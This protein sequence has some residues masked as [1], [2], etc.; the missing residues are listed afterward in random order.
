MA[1]H[2][3][4]YYSPEEYLALERVDK[5]KNEYLAGRIYA[6]SGGTPTHA[7]IAMNVGGEIRTQ[8]KGSECRVFSSDLKVRSGAS[9]LFAYPDVTVVCGNL[10]YHDSKADVITNPVVIVEVL[11]DSTEAFDRGDKFINYRQIESLA[12]YLLVSQTG[13]LVEHYTKLPD[14]K[15][16]LNPVSGLES[17]IEIRS[18]GCTL[19]LS[20]IYDKI[21]F[22]A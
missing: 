5:Y 9:T 14:G 10:E 13:C 16:I 6:M 21:E 22:K 20:E 1:M 17:E 12:D 2:A 19:R 8:L 3:E 11:S 18:I 4:R 7:A 15:W